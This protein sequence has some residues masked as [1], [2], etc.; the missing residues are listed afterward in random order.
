[1]R[2]EG[3]PFMIGGPGGWPVF[4]DGGSCDL[5]RSLPSVCVGSI[6]LCRAVGRRSQNATKR[7]A[8]VGFL[9]KHNVFVA[10][11]DIVAMMIACCVA[12]AIL[13][14]RVNVTVS[15]SRGRHSALCLCVLQFCG[16]RSIL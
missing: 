1:M 11:C 9:R 10:F 15:F 6:A 12:A 4:A 2:S 13:W 8:G 7:C 3:F 5:C 14:K 16:R